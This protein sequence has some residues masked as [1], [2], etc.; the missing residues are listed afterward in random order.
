MGQPPL[1]A[2]RPVA[3]AR[4]IAPA[5]SSAVVRDFI[6]TIMDVSSPVVDLNDAWF[7]IV[8]RPFVLSLAKTKAQKGRSAKRR[9]L[10]E[11]KSFGA[12]A[13]QEVL[14]LLIVIEHHPMV[15]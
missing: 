15:F 10:K 2:A 11:A 3:G 8:T 14:G 5:A 4:A 9:G 6:P 13:D 1:S 12:V 7:G